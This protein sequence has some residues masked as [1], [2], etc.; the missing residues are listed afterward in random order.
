MPN[1]VIPKPERNGWDVYQALFA[2]N[3]AQF[4]KGAIYQ[5]LRKTQHPDP[6]CAYNLCFG[7]QGLDEQDKTF[8]IPFGKDLSCHARQLTHVTMKLGSDT[9]M[10]EDAKKVTKQIVDQWFQFVIDPKP[11]SMLTCVP[12]LFVSSKH[13][14]LALINDALN[15]GSNKT[16]PEAWYSIPK[17]GFFVR[18]IPSFNVTSTLRIAKL[19]IQKVKTTNQLRQERK[20]KDDSDSGSD[21]DSSYGVE[22][23]GK[24]PWENAAARAQQNTQD[25]FDS[26]LSKGCK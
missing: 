4:L 18:G 14:P 25:N 19:K 17:Q 8:I 2:Y 12:M 7:L 16:R 5:K 26:V 11:D 20:E 13:K 15:F 23:N 22:E 9:F 21:S 3:G 1:K 10:D 6:K 24:F